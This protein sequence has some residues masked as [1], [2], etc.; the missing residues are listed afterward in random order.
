VNLKIE[1]CLE[2]YEVGMLPWDIEKTVE[3]PLSD[4]ED[5]VPESVSD[6]E[7]ESEK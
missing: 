4:D 7:S 1:Q 3:D 2:F 5:G 6:S